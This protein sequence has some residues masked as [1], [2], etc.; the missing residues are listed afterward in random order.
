MG[1]KMLLDQVR[2]DLN[3]IVTKV[4]VLGKTFGVLNVEVI[5]VSDIIKINQLSRL[6]LDLAKQCWEKCGKSSALAQKNPSTETTLSVAQTADVT[7]VTPLP[8]VPSQSQPCLL[9]PSND[10]AN[11]PMIVLNNSAIQIS[12]VPKNSNLPKE[13][14][15]PPPVKET[16]SVESR[17]LTGTKVISLIA[18]RLFF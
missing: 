15:P 5:S 12:R 10:G 4:E 14:P 11:K 9:V 6:T 17:I 8:E 7:P 18:N 16:P 2:S 3:E 1:S 13:S